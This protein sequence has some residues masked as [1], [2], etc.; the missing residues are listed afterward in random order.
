MLFVVLAVL[1]LG[2]AV[3]KILQ[4]YKIC[5]LGVVSCNDTVVLMLFC[6]VYLLFC[7]CLGQVCFNAVLCCLFVVLLLFRTSFTR[8]RD[9]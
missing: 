4:T 5:R 1:C 9:S 3:A 6:V 2:L 8:W 7:S